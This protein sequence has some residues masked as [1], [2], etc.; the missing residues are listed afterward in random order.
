MAQSSGT[1][2]PAGS[3]TT[4]RFGHSATILADGRVLIAGG[5]TDSWNPL[6]YPP[7][8]H[9]VTDTA[10]IYDPSTGAFTPPAT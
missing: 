10:E 7:D 6:P 1:F 3:M 5:Y 8:G 2:T 9:A 4:A